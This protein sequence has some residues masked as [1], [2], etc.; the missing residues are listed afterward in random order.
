MLIQMMTKGKP[1]QI[2]N[3]K[4]KIEELEKATEQ[5][6]Q[7]QQV[8]NTLGNEVDED[9]NNLLSQS[10]LCHKCFSQFYEKIEHICGRLDEVGDSSGLSEEL[11]A[12]L[13][14][15]T[16]FDDDDDE[17]SSDSVCGHAK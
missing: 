10:T 6:Y 3:L 15:M 17:E 14:E 12:E 4:T 1:S 2:A 8:V 9:M 5:M 13:E 16:E 7:S 11:W